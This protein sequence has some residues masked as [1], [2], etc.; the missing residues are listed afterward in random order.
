MFLDNNS[1][2]TQVREVLANEVRLAKGENDINVMKWMSRAALEYIGQGGLGYSFD[3]LD[4]TKVNTYSEVIKMFR[5]ASCFPGAPQG[6]LNLIETE[7]GLSPIMFDL[8]TI[9]QLIPYASKVGPA[10]LRRVALQLLPNR[11]IQR[12]REIVDT[13]DS[14][15]HN[16][17]DKKKQAMIGG[18]GKEEGNE[19]EQVGKGKDIMSVLREC[20][21]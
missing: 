7:H 13:M 15:A 18:T 19:S 1:R 12:A 10:W 4:E 20:S 17:Y 16:I 21:G 8:V 5:C 14:L 11:R 9:R 3:A 6:S 2:S